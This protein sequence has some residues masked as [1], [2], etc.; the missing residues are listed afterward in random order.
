MNVRNCDVTP[1]IYNPQIGQVIFCNRFIDFLVF[2][3]PPQKVALR[4]LWGDVLVV[5]I[6]RRHFQR[7]VSSDNCGIVANGLQENQVEA[8]LFL[9]SLLDPC[10]A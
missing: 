10:S 1:N 8:F 2:L 3:N 6:T 5:G 7:N 4:H 9:Y